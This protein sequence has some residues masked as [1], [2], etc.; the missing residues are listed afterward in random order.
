MDRQ[1]D[2]LT[3][4]RAADRRRTDQ[5]TDRTDGTNGQ[6]DYMREIKG[7]WAKTRLLTAASL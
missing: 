2:R 7:I 6:I 4:G 1:T 3:D 5:G